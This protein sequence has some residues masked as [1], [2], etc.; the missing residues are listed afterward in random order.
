LIAQAQA[1][2][3]GLFTL[4]ALVL[5]VAAV[6]V[7]IGGRLFAPSEAVVMHFNGSV[8]GLDVGAPVVLRGV[9]VGSVRS[10]SLQRQGQGLSVPVV[11]ELALPPLG[12]AGLKSLLAQGL[13][14]QLATQSLLTG[15][16]YVEL[17]LRPAAGLPPPPPAPAGLIAVPTVGQRFES[18]QAQLETLDVARIAQD[19]AAVL[20]SARTFSDSPETRT[21]LADLARSSA[22]LARLTATLDQRSAP[23]ASGADEALKHMGRAAEQL[24]QA[25]ERMAGSVDGAAGRVGAAAGTAQALLTPGSPLLASLQK[26]ADELARSAATLA[27][28]TAPD[29][30]AAQRL[31]RTAAEVARAARS[32]RELTTLLQE[33][34]EAL[35]RGRRAETG[36]PP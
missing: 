36:A 35:L 22:S 27:A 18:L 20:A 11:A 14:A 33:Q 3:I 21:A 15:Q 6:A 26:A 4:G 9:R 25:A 10:I 13:S 32:L 1:L 31:E 19:L 8:R 23:L 12:D 29:G 24:G 17:D 16:L 30:A 2:R 34:P 7:I 28:A 5:L